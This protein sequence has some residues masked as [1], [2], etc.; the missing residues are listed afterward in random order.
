M[1]LF[2]KMGDTHVCKLEINA[3]PYLLIDKRM[4]LNR[5]LEEKGEINMS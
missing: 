4:S 1:C 5:V 3:W 2:G